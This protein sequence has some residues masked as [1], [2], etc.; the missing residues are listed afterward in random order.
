MANNNNSNRYY[1]SLPVQAPQQPRS[2]SGSRRPPLTPSTVSSPCLTT[3][4]TIASRR[5]SGSGS[6]TKASALLAKVAS[7]PP[8]PRGETPSASP[9][10][11]PDVRM[12]STPMYSPERPAVW[13]SESARYVH[14]YRQQDGYISFPDFEKFCQSQN[15]YQNQQR[16]QNAVQT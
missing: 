8:T 3:Q 1:Y 10:P 12:H 7:H 11:S 5:D 14:Q 13:R 4:S 2:A 16:E 6:P 9:M 15:P